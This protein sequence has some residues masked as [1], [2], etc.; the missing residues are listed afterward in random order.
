MTYERG[1]L[2]SPK[3]CVPK[4]RRATA[5]NYLGHLIMSVPDVN[6]KARLEVVRAENGAILPRKTKQEEASRA[7]DA[8]GKMTVC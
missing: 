2:V 8:N 5:L 4:N 7:S 1:G 3:G 6:K